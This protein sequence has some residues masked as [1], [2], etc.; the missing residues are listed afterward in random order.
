[1]LTGIQGYRSGNTLLPCHRPV[2]GP[3]HS[4]FSKKK[5]KKFCFSKEATGLD[6]SSQMVE[7]RVGKW[8]VRVIISPIL[9][10]KVHSGY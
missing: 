1:V 3:N 8:H 2:V 5:G 9:R 6:G 4:K 10:G 7:G